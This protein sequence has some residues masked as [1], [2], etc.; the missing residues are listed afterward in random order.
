MFPAVRCFPDFSCTASVCTG[1]SSHAGGTG[2]VSGGCGKGGSSV[3]TSGFVIGCGSAS[4]TRSIDVRILSSCGFSSRSALYRKRMRHRR[5]INGRLIRRFRLFF[6]RVDNG[7]RLH[8]RRRHRLHRLRFRRRIQHHFAAALRPHPAYTG[9]QAALRA[10][11]GQRTSYRGSPSRRISTPWYTASNTGRSFTKRTSSF[12]GCTFT[13]TTDDGSSIVQHARREFTHHNR[14][15]VRF[16]LA[17]HTPCGCA[18]N[19]R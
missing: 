17:P 12:A 13:S 11:Q 8:D 1:V 9:Q 15:L 2:S 16:L 7:R 6:A 10:A 19:A 18:Q 4:K 5:H 14:A 3:I